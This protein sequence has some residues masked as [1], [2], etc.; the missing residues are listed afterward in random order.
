MNTTHYCIIGRVYY[1]WYVLLVAAAAMVG[2]LPGRTQGLGLI[3]EPLLA[4]LGI[5]R[6]AY[7]EVNLWA[8]LVGSLGAIGIGHLLDRFGSRVVLTSVALALGLVVV[9]MSQTASVLG[10]AVWITL[11]RALGQSALSVVSLAMIAPWFVRK[12]DTAMALYSVAL[13]VGFMLAFPAVGAMVQQRG[14]RSCLAGRWRRDRRRAGAARLERRAARPRGDVAPPGRG[15]GASQAS[16]AGQRVARGV[17]LGQRRSTEPAFW[18]FAIGTALYGLVASG[19]GLFNESILAERGFGAGVYYQTLVVT[20]LTALAGNFAG[21]WLARS[22]SLARLMGVSLLVLAGGVVALPHV[23]TL[24]HVMTWATAMGLGGGLVMVLFFT[25]WP[26]VFGR[27]HLGRI[28]GTAQ[29]LTVVAS[30]LG[31]LLLAW[32]VEWTG[33]YA[34]MFR[35]LAG[36]ISLVA[37]SALPGADAVGGASEDGRVVRDAGVDARDDLAGAGGLCRRRGRQDP[38]VS[39]GRRAAL[40]VAGLVRRPGRLRRPHPDRDGAPP[41]L[42]PRGRGAGDGPADGGGLRRGVGRRRLRQLPVCRRLAGRAGL[43]ARRSAALRDAAAVDASGWCGPSTSS[44]S[45]TPP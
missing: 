12:V 24:A 7:A 19:I 17:H 30:A 1:G 23:A 15:V 4:E 6:V 37:L 38:A 5:G 25:V 28:Q 18:I 20:A 3:T 13:S 9:A 45:S 2:T 8:T 11:T 40:G 10:L 29:A 14:W 22:V 27:R 16:T 41:R 34:T 44:S 32:C 42:E 36:L 26:R 35:V 31:P 39:D 21:G 43:V 33:S